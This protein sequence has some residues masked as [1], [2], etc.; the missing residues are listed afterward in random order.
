MSSTRANLR[1]ICEEFDAG[2]HLSFF[3]ALAIDANAVAAMFE[4]VE[5]G[6]ADE[7]GYDARFFV[8]TDS[9][10]LA[11]VEETGSRHNEVWRNGEW[12]PLGKLN[13]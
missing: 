13:R 2:Q 3:D 8:L 4:S 6:F 7:F 10:E 12:L 9:G 11:F 1:Q 5:D